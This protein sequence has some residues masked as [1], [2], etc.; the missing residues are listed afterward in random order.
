[1]KKSKVTEKQLEDVKAERDQL[2]TKM[3]K[4]QEEVDKLRSKKTVMRK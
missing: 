2:S 1:M 4:L 3:A